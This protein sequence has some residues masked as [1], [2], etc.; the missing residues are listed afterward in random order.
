MLKQIAKAACAM[1]LS[2][3]VLSAC[4]GKPEKAGTAVV[5]KVEQPAD[6]AARQAAPPAPAGVTIEVEV[7]AT[8]NGKPAAGARV[9]AGGAAVGTTDEKGYLLGTTVK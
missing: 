2:L 9:A 8:M 6:N 1:S 3:L 4:Q 5:K 7:L